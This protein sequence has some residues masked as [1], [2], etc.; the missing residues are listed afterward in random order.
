MLTSNAIFLT[1]RSMGLDYQSQSCCLCLNLSMNSY[2]RP[3]VV[4]MSQKSLSY[5]NI[6]L[7]IEKQF[8]Q[9][10]ASPG[11]VEAPT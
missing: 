3:A 4:M 10:A 5:P 9:T 7:I 6:R 1:L 11:H 2:I 8:I